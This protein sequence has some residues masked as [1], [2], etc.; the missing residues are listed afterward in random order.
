MR[1][2]SLPLIGAAYEVVLR[3]ALVVQLDPASDRN[4][5]LAF[6]L[7]HQVPCGEEVLQLPHVEAQSGEDAGDQASL[8]RRSF[9]Q[10]L[11]QR[12]ERLLKSASRL[13]GPLSA[14][15][16]PLGQLSILEAPC[17][18]VLERPHGV[19]ALPQLLEL[20]GRAHRGQL[21]AAQQRFVEVQRQHGIA[22]GFHGALKPLLSASQ[23][24]LDRHVLDGLG[25]QA[26][27]LIEDVNRFRRRRK[28]ATGVDR[29]R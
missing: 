15:E 3:A 26:V 17:T 8:R 28:D 13:A 14:R 18:L 29:E 12:D 11:A 6:L 7:E 2:R 1:S 9:Q 25:G 24:M 23:R 19:D 16:H 27:R 10:G 22:D 20:V 4:L 21:G 5:A